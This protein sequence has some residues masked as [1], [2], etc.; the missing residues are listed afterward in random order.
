MP[1]PRRRAE[2][3]CT[4]FGLRL[5]ILQAPMASASPPALAAA[6]SNAGGM[7]GLGALMSDPAGIA[8][9][10]AEFRGRSN[11]SFQV[12]LWIPDPAPPRDAAREDGARRTIAALGPPPPEVGDGPW[13]QDFA[14]QC[15]A[16]LAV[17]PPVVSSIMGVFESSFV[18]EMKA[19]GIL[20]ICN[21]TTLEEARAAEA[22]G[23]DA[24]VAQGA[25]A[26]GHRGAFDPER[27]ETQNIG[28]FALIPRFADA[29]SVP[30]I[31]AGGVMDGRGVAAAL[32]LGASAVQMGTAFL[33]CPEAGI[34]IGYA[35]ALAEA[36]PEDT[37]LTRAFSG[38]LARSVANAATRAFEGAE[39]APYPIQR[40]L[41]GPMRA[42]A[43]KTDD[44][45][46]M[47][48]WAG[49]GVA[50]SRAEPAADLARRVWA[51]AEAMLP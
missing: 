27:A 46:R 4:R 7:G 33:R 23:A 51:E 41:S 37:V 30:V 9:W 18:Q 8:A 43:G 42:E 48:L 2:T 49:Q 40:H 45:S 24:V 5:P 1:T 16:L 3:F 28:L 14:A 22:A 10:A 47:Q 19:R 35:R 6:V 44:P 32:L 38:R 20:W 21:A 25:E 11:G 34:A 17:R 13:T 50:L 39:P 31:A 15:E 36:G 29:L 26:G 12:N